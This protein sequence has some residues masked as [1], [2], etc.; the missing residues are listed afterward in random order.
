MSKTEPRCPHCEQQNLQLEV[1]TKGVQTFEWNAETGLWDSAGYD[2]TTTA[3]TGRVYCLYCDDAVIIAQ[4]DYENRIGRAPL[5]TINI[6]N[7]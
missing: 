7:L 3:R 1:A 5:S 4:H 2:V 6:H